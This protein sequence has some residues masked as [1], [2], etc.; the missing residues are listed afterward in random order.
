M[1]SFTI[2]ATLVTTLAFVSNGVEAGHY[3]AGGNRVEN[4]K[5]LVLAS[6]SIQAKKLASMFVPGN[7]AEVEMEEVLFP[8]TGGASYSLTWS[9]D[10]IIK[11]VKIIAP[12]DIALDGSE[13]DFVEG[14]DFTVK[15]E[16]HSFVLECKDVSV[17]HI[18][19]ITMEGVKRNA[20]QK[21]TNLLANAGMV[22]FCA[23]EP[24]FQ[25]P[26][27]NQSSDDIP[28]DRFICPEF[29]DCD[30]VSEN[31]IDTIFPNKDDSGES[32]GGKEFS[33]VVVKSLDDLIQ[34]ICDKSTS[35]GEIKFDASI[36][37]FS[38][39]GKFAVG[40][41][42]GPHDIVEFLN[43]NF[44]NFCTKLRGKLQILTIYSG[45][46]GKDRKGECFSQS[47]ANCL[48]ADVHYFKRPLT[49]GK[50][51]IWGAPKGFSAPSVAKPCM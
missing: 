24:P 51:N 42:G 37:V 19:V 28:K 14:K 12:H 26:P 11:K 5:V 20:A 48:E 32:G 16:E 22:D 43:E 25:C 30:F 46:V 36:Y 23:P 45:A 21:S 9:T 6:N 33:G 39:S 35:L 49:V 44:F 3:K 34:K 31:T 7:Y 8:E 17:Y 1:C 27:Q 38:A 2:L 29:D 4:S 15:V 10:D 41:R 40:P 18:S 50:N 13:R 47:L